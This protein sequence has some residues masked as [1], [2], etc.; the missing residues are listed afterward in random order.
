MLNSIIVAHR[1]GQPG[2]RGKPDPHIA[3][4]R[5][6]QNLSLSLRH[7]VIASSPPPSREPDPHIRTDRCVANKLAR[8]V[9][10][11]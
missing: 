10:L 8:R 7:C 2:D 3:T 6:A 4:E 5:R 1:A 11:P 9:N